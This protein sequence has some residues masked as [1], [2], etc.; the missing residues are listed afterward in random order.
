MPHILYL[1]DSLTLGGAETMVTNTLNYLSLKYPSTKISLF[2]TLE[3]DGLLVKKLSK[4]VNY[5]H[6]NCRG[7][8]L[9]RSTLNIKKYIRDNKVT[10]VHSHLY[11]SILV[12]RMITNSKIALIETYHNLEY[13]PSSVYYSKWRVKLD[14]LTFKKKTTSIYVSEKVK[15]SIEKSRP[16]GHTNLVL[17]NFAGV[18]FMY[19]YK[20]N[21]ASS[22]KLIAVGTINNDKNFLFALQTFSH[23]KQ[24]DISLDIYGDGLLREELTAY[25]ETNKINVRLMG[26]VSVTMEIFE[27]YDAFLMTSLNE[28]MPISLLEALNFGLPCIL[29]DHLPVMKQ[30]AGKAGLYFSIKNVESLKNLL[31]K[32]FNDKDSLQAMTLE[33]RTQSKLFSI[34]AH[35]NRLADIYKLDSLNCKKTIIIL[36]D[37][38]KRGGAEIMLVSLLPDLNKIYNVVLVTLKGD[39]EFTENEIKTYAKYNLDFKTFVDLP[40]SIGTLK[41]IIQ[42]HSPIL[43][44]THLFFS[45]IIGRLSVSNQIPFVFSIHSLLS[46]D[47]FEANKMSLHLEKFTYNK[48]QAI[49]IV[50]ETVFKDYAAHIN[51]KGRH[52]I[53]NNFVDKTFFEKNYDFEKH[54]LSTFKFVAVGNLI[55]VKNYK[56]LLRV[57]KEVKDKV[58]ITL[59]II[60]EG[61]SRKDLEQFINAHKLPVK[62]LG[63]RNDVDMLLPNYD[64]LIMCSLHEGFGNAPVEAMAVGVPLILN[65][66]E[67]MKEMSKGNALFYKSNDVGSLA[68]ILSAFGDSKEELL[69]LSEEGKLI[70]REFYS[71]DSYFLRLKSIYDGLM[72][73]QLNTT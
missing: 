20:F 19:N 1:I 6:I 56:F 21:S 71:H 55:E 67:V 69:R 61:D 11:H 70:A 48:R 29:P 53:L 50:S 22:L 32:L 17:N 45:T 58:P 18:E 3:E 40:R 62:L 28:G 47:A 10:H 33:C 65:D 25:I 41:R 64:G 12:G 13:D 57:I 8:N 7:L 2:T 26:S 39:E 31:L 23:L 24:T 51:V 5:L 42:H 27:N 30:V 44:H 37:N 54:N 49:I 59:D 9:L 60:G 38:L 36:I 52:F 46:K 66:L 14:K 43:V 15:Q 63:T 34:D 72:T 73:E 16:K 35:V 4:N 68:Q